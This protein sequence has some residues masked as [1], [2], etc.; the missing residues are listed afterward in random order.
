M[1]K[2]IIQESKAYF[3]D[4][5]DKY[6]RGKLS[7]TEMIRLCVVPFHFFF[8]RGDTTYAEVYRSFTQSTTQDELFEMVDTCNF[9]DMDTVLRTIVSYSN[10]MFTVPN[11]EK[12]IENLLKFFRKSRKTGTTF[13]M[14]EKV[15]DLGWSL[16]SSP[17]KVAFCLENSHY[18]EKMLDSQC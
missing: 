4:G 14:C 6:C 10:G 16:N 17:Y 8:V 5:Y 2:E 1:K 11:G 18:Y 9:D 15:I 13:H 7:K 3:I 12:Q